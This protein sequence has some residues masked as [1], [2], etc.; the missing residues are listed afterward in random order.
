MPVG[1][2]LINDDY[3]PD[4]AWADVKRAVD[5]FLRVHPHTGFRHA[6]GKC[7]ATKT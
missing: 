4:G 3:F 1:G 5:D 2:I 6:S 7:R